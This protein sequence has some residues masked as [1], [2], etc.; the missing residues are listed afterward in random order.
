MKS[1][2]SFVALLFCIGAGIF[3]CAASRVVTEDL[4]VTVQRG[5]PSAVLVPV[6]ENGYTKPT[7]AVIPFAQMGAHGNGYA[8]RDSLKRDLSLKAAKL[9]ADCVWVSNSE[10]KNAGTVTSYGNGFAMSEPVQCLSMY[11]QACVWS[12]VRVGLAID[13]DNKVTD[14]IPG[15]AAD[16]AGLKINDRILAM[17]KNRLTGDPLAMSR[18][19]A[20]VVPGQ[21]VDTE[22]VGPDNV[23]RHISIKCERND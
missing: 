20:V 18:A 10:V 6:F 13:K 1:L 9:G 19:L 12:P 8:T 16:R 11:G 7:R 21:E 2:M 14:V 5:A 15:G 4:P 23:T 22:I 3:G 17:N